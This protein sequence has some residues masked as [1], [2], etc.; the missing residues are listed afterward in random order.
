MPIK[1]KRIYDKYSEDDGFRILVERLWPRG[2]S[3]V[4]AHI[5]LWLKDV[6]PSTEL[7]KWF[8]HEDDKWDEFQ[9]RYKDELKNNSAL[10]TLRSLAVEHRNITLVFSSSN[11]AHNNAV[12]LYNLLKQ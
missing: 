12:V 8:N 6:A 3:K 9:K 7:R 11:Q 10:K 4:E 2:I 5:D 1:L